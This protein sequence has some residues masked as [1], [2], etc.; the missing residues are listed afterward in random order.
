[1]S[2]DIEF[3]VEFIV[4]GTP[5]SLQAKRR[6]SLDEWKARVVEASRTVLPESHFATGDPV[7]ITLFYFPVSDMQGDLDNIVKP[8]LDALARHV[9]ID[10]RQVERILIQKFEPGKVVRF[11]RPSQML[12]SALNH[13]RPVLYVR[14]SDD[15]FEDP[16]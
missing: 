4:P 6:P 16:M 15:P 14:V 9:Y 2:I 7:A 1:M 5:V 10:D 13:P 12:E 11:S 8:I 3:P